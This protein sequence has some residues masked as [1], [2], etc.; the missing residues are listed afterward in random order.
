MSHS[1][2]VAIYEKSVPPNAIV[3]VIEVSPQLTIPIICIESG[4]CTVSPVPPSC[5]AQSMFPFSC[6]SALTVNFPPVQRIVVEP[7]NVSQG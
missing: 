6:L 4:T 1:P 5:E 7:E 2:L 3:P